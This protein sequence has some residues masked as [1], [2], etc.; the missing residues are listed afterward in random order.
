MTGGS[1]GSIEEYFLSRMNPGDVFWFAGKCLMLVRVRNNVAYVRKTKGTKGQIP[2]WQGG[3]MPLSSQLSAM[4]RK[5]IDEVKHNQS[6]EIEMKVLKP[7]FDLQEQ[8]SA[9]PGLKE[10][11]IE[12]LETDEGHHCFF[13]PFEGRLVHEGMAAL[14]AYRIALIKP[15]SFSIAMNDYGFELLSDMEIPLEEA[16]AEDLFSTENLLA[17][18]QASV[19]ATEMSMRRFREIAR[20]AGLIFQGYPGRQEKERH[21]QSSTSLLFKVFSEYDPHNLLLR[22]SY[23]EVLD[24]QLEELR[25]RR[26]LM[27]INSQQVLIKYPPKPTPFAFPI[28]VDRMREKLTSEKLEERV[29]KMQVRFGEETKQKEVRK[30][31]IH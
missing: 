14:F 10:F 31:I 21:L 24:F 7:L 15:I 13:F 12:K 6:K 4:I 25:L 17:Y 9:L 28:M 5:K 26:A 30:K 11:L 20:V 22:Q 29:R 19:N 27:R 16:I 8:R 2:S 3:R 1:I 23:Q 18:I